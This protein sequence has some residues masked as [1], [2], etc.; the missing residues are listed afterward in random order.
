MIPVDLRDQQQRRALEVA[1]QLARVRCLAQQ[2]ELDPDLDLWETAKPFLERWMAEQVGWR[3]FVERVKQEAPYWSTILPQLPRL[4][5]QA[6][7]RQ[8]QAPAG[9]E[10]TELLREARLR[11]RILTAIALVLALTAVLLFV[12]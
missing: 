12:R 1:P 5:H 11:N 2:I 7:A 6:L 8:A 9:E 10:L 3:G 4:L